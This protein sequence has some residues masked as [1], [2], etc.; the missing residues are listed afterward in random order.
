MQKKTKQPD[1]LDGVPRQWLEEFVELMEERGTCPRWVDVKCFLRT[2]PSRQPGIEIAKE[3]AN[4]RP[5]EPLVQSNNSRILA[6][7]QSIL[8]ETLKWLEALEIP[9][10]RTLSWIV[11]RDLGDVQLIIEH[12]PS[13]RFMV[14]FHTA[15]TSLLM[16]IVSP[17]EGFALRPR[18]HGDITKVI[19]TLDHFKDNWT[20]SGT[21]TFT[22]V[23][24]AG[25][26]PDFYNKSRRMKFDHGQVQ[27]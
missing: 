25:S 21:L 5:I 8:K 2:H 11:D 27:S 10:T 12:S 16:Q 9:Y 26:P 4:N 20:K 22:P 3:A 15:D 14:R 7:G 19:Q 17:N 13:T 24:G 6:I 1:L 23:P 18:I